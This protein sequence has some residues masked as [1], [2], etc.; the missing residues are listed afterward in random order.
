MMLH[1]FNACAMSL[2]ASCREMQLPII[3]VIGIACSWMV[4]KGVQHLNSPDVFLDP[5]RRSEHVGDGK[6]SVEEGTEWSKRVATNYRH[7]CAF[8]GATW[9][10]VTV[11]VPSCPSSVLTV[12]FT[13]S[14]TPVACL[15]ITHRTTAS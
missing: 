5:R 9:G 4:Y 3:G 11:D 7:K 2:F 14:G 13:L 12:R 6:Y 10:A 15:S 1:H 8:S